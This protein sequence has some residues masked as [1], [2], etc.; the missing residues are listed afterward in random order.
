MSN[1]FF[2]PLILQALAI[3]GLVGGAALAL[4]LL[5]WTDAEV[6]HAARSVATLAEKARGNRLGVAAQ[7]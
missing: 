4:A 7:G 6:A 2:A 5:P 3:F 1:G